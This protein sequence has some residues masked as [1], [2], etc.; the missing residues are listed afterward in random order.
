LPAWAEG[1]PCSGFIWNVS[2]ERALFST[3]PTSVIAGSDLASAPTVRIDGFYELK[4]RPQSELS[5]A[6]PPGKRIL[7]DGAYAGIVRF[8]VTEPGIYRVSSSE[9]VWFD[10][11]AQ[12]SLVRSTDFQGSAGCNTPRKVVEFQL[13]PSVGLALQFSGGTSPSIRISVTPAPAPAGK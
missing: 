11:V 4:L 6:A 3:E 12:G 5:F 2:H 1:D 9:P 8:D 7:T 13:A 10:I